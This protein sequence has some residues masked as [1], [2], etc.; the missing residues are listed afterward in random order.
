MRP[1][2]GSAGERRRVAAFDVDGTLTRRDCVVPFLRRIG[3]TV[4]PAVRLLARPG[5]VGGVARRDRD[6]LKAAASY[7]AFSG[8]SAVEVEEAAVEFAR[9]V[10]GNWMRD[11]TVGHLHWHRAAGDLV[12]LISASYEVYLR[13][14]AAAIDVDEVLATRLAV[15]DGRLTGALDGTNCRGPEKVRRLHEWLDRLGVGRAGAHV[16]AYGDSTGDRELLIDADVAHW[17]GNRRRP[18]WFPG[19][20]A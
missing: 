8:R 14:L 15:V 12:V 1:D 4:Q 5:L 9:H 2:N 11:D 17:A 18:H 13:P 20:A 3:G 19:S 6:A 7:A 16:T 10:H